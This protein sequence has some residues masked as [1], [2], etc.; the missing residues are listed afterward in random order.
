L[1]SSL[2]A[3]FTSSFSHNYHGPIPGSYILRSL[4]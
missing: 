4:P 3:P 1:Q 2:Q